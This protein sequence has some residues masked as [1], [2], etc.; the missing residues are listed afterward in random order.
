MH[1]LSLSNLDLSM[2]NLH[3]ATLQGTSG[4]TCSNDC[5]KREVAAGHVN[6]HDTRWQ[7]QPY[8]NKIRK[9]ENEYQS[10]EESEYEVEVL[11]ENPAHLES[12]KRT[13][14]FQTLEEPGQTNGS[15]DISRKDSVE[16]IDNRF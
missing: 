2:T 5:S 4:D 3:G 11:P 7:G 14:K 15:L 9:E 13:A 12:A 16:K 6:G 10:K 8:L 1:L